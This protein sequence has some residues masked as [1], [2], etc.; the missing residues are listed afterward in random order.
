MAVI[1]F[2]Y[3]TSLFFKNDNSAQSYTMFFNFMMIST[4]SSFVFA[5]RGTPQLEKTGDDLH[6]IF[7]VIPCYSVASSVFFDAM[8]NT[9]AK[10]REW[11][12]DE[13]TG[14]LLDKNIGCHQCHWRRH[15]FPR[16]FRRLVHS[17]RHLGEDCHEPR[18]DAQGN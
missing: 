5:F 10:M 6:I 12:G 15:C 13:G 17:P 2:T 14:E 16:S 3:V 9:L 11:S 1:P 7:K 8:G 18:K 4:F